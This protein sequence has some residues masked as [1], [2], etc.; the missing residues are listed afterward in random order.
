[1]TVKT[2]HGVMEKTKKNKTDV[3]GDPVSVVLKG[4]EL[5][6]V[7]TGLEWIVGE[8]TKKGDKHSIGLAE[9]YKELHKKFLIKYSYI[10]TFTVG[11]FFI[12]RG[13][14]FL[15]LGVNW[16]STPTPPPDSPN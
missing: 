10:Y 16:F 3:E 9:T 2:L 12:P 8:K 4:L 11:T 6:L 15:N 7:L 13:F 5:C 1:M 14:S